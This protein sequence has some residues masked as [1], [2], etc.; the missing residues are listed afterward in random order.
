LVGIWHSV[1]FRLFIS[2]S[3]EVRRFRCSDAAVRP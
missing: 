3:G 1:P 2:N